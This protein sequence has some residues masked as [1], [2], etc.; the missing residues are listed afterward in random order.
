LSPVACLV[1]QS[2]LAQRNLLSLLECFQQFP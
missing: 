1:P 2:L